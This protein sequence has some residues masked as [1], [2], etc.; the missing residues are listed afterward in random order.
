MIGFLRGIVHSVRE[1]SC[2]LDVNGVGYAVLMS[3]RNLSE[4]KKDKTVFLYT[5]MIVRED[6]MLLCGFLQAQEYELFVKLIGISGIGA[7]AA[8][9]ALS[10]TTPEGFIAAVQTKDLKMLM[11]LP[12]IGK[13][14]AERILLELDGKFATVDVALSDE[15]SLTEPSDVNAQVKDVIMALQVLGYD[16]ARSMSLAK[17][18]Y[19]PGMSV[20]DCIK[21]CLKELARG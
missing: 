18:L 6:A 19:L 21:L 12:G 20:Q 15:T 2:L 14:T 9:G 17:A 10:G 8:L 1:D 11:K 7:K 5:Y 3:T 4:L 16:G 13:K